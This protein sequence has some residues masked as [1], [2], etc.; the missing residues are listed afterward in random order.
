MRSIWRAG[1]VM[2]MVLAAMVATP[3]RAAAAGS[4]IDW[5]ELNTFGGYTESYIPTG[6]GMFVLGEADI[7]HLHNGTAWDSG[8]GSVGNYYSP[9]ASVTTSG[10]EIRYTLALPVGSLIYSRTDYDGGLHSSNGKLVS[11]DPIV[12]R[13]TQGAKTA[14]LTGYAKLTFDQY[15]NYTD[16]RYHF[17]NA[18]VG[19]LVPFDVT[20]TITSAHTWQ[21]NLMDGSFSYKIAGTL[22]F[23]NA[24]TPEPTGAAGLALLAGPLLCRRRRRGRQ[25]AARA[26][27]AET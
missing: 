9:V 17:F 1:W 27:R 14:K 23:A 8:A 15:A 11:T 26:D 19:S 10:S 16:D 20:Y 25:H 12:L 5:I 2:I 21:P 22:D 13:A 4:P 24:I 7:Y 3:R 18:P 6:S